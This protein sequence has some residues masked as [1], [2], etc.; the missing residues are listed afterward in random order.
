M[1]T[2]YDVKGKFYQT[3]ECD[4]N[5]VQRV[6]QIPQKQNKHCNLPVPYNHL[7]ER[8]NDAKANIY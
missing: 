7:S 6:L 4:K 3:N 1:N 5:S 8:E 2:T